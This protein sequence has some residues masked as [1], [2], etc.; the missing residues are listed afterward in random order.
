MGKD[1]DDSQL[2]APAP[3]RHCV[4]C[5][6]VAGEYLDGL[7]ENPAVVSFRSE[8]AIKCVDCDVR[9]EEDR[10]KYHRMYQRCV[11]R[12]FRR[13]KVAHPDEFDRLLVEERQKVDEERKKGNEGSS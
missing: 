13:L 1:D 9:A 12:A 11:A 8:L 3:E 2:I 5:G 6:K 10:K 7:G 4:G